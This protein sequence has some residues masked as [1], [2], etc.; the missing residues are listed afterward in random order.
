MKELINERK[1]KV[2]INIE[3]E[4]CFKQMIP[5]NYCSYVLNL[6][7]I[8]KENNELIYIYKCCNCGAELRLT[9]KPFLKQLYALKFE[10][11]I[12]NDVQI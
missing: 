12:K 2:M 4:E 8:K 5:C 7:D 10:K 9:Y 6:D 11:W 1:I 3:N